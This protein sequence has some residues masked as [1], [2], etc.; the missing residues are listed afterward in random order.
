M[1]INYQAT[2]TNAFAA[3]DTLPASE[4]HSGH[5]QALS[6]L[7]CLFDD[8][9]KGRIADMGDDDRFLRQAERF[10]RIHGLLVERA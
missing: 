2:A 7:A 3:I 1:T 4:K 6:N 5:G 9:A 8:V 10:F